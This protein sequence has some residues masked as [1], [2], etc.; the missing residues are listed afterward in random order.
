MNKYITVYDKCNRLCIILLLSNTKFKWKWF[1][2]DHDHLTNFMEEN[3]VIFYCKINNNILSSI[4]S[5]NR[6]KIIQQYNSF[7]ELI[8]DYPTVILM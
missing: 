7:E 1:I 3:I 4:F 2:D 6:Y 5:E 8:I